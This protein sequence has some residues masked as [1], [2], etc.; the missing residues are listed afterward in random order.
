MLAARPS[1]YIGSRHR[2]NA[3]LLLAKNF[4]LVKLKYSVVKSYLL[5]YFHKPLQYL[6]AWGSTPSALSLAVFMS[7]QT[8][9]Q[10][11]V[12]LKHP[13]TGAD[14]YIVGTSHVSSFYGFCAYE[15]VRHLQPDVVYLEVDEVRMR[16]SLSRLFVAFCSV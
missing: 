11:C 14:V 13:E 16:L 10:P 2:R 3:Q 4:T 12:L 5:A 7:E 6:G 15:L 1:V 9:P 8:L